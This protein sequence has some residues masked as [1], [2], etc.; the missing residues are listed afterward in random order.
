SPFKYTE[1]S[2]MQQYFKME[3]KVVS[4]ARFLITQ[5]GWDWRKSV[6]L[7]RYLQERSIDIPVLGNVYLLTTMTPAP[8]LM[9]DGKLPGCFVSDELLAQ[10]KNE[11]IDDHID[12]AAQQVAMYQAIGAAGVDI[13]GLPDFASF[14]KILQRAAEIGSGWE[15][16]KGNLHWPGRGGFYLYDETREQPVPTKRRKPLRRRTFNLVHRLVLDPDHA[17]FK[18]WRRFAK[19][20]GAQKGEGLAYK[21]FATLEKAIKYAAFDCQDCG[22]CYPPENFGFCTRGKC[23]KGLN[24]APCGDSTV[25]GQC[26]N[27]L[28]SRCTGERIY[29]TA[30]TEPDGV[31]RL[32]STINLPRIPELEHTSSILN[33]L[34][35]RDHTKTRPLIAVGDQIDASHPKTGAVMKEALELGDEALQQ[36]IGPV[37]YIRALIQSQADEGADYIAVNID[38][39]CDDDGQQA[40]RTME[41]YVRWVRDHGGGIPPC[42]DSVFDEALAAGL[43]AWY[44]DDQPALPPLLSSIRAEAIKKVMPLRQEHD[45]GL[46]GPLGHTS[47]NAIDAGEAL[48]Q[49]KRL[50]ERAVT[51]YGFEAE[52]L[53]FNPVAVPL[54][55]DEPTVPGGC[56]HTYSAFETMRRIKAD[57]SLKRCHCL[58]RTSAVVPGLPGRAIGVCRAYVGK[59]LEYGLDAAFTNV[60]NHYGESPADPGL[61][62]LVSAFAEMDGTSGR[63][64]QAKKHMDKFCAAT[65]KP[66]KAPAP[67]GPKSN[68]IPIT[69]A[70]G[71]AKAPQDPDR[72]PVKS[73]RSAT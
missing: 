67:A 57:A 55:K 64:E 62:E 28:E 32:R 3:K 33:Y 13:G 10:L 21:S 31:E 70:P 68:D 9:H 58:L 49:A 35:G 47:T 15:R 66:R 71:K 24:N 22:D 73:A 23:E 39:L 48:E 36:P 26:G 37:G 65:R 29:E 59:A 60:A 20:T 17:G 44:S 1:A 50:F 45:F 6:E 8:R 51:E 40:A 19:L 25:D 30:V 11:S 72:A 14:V 7:M 43:K 41:Q 42:I 69:A 2:Q 18:V 61:L 16:H 54:V 53:F 56:G 34:A 46:V 12:R 4:G 63:A 52:Q 5:V 27:N 38:A